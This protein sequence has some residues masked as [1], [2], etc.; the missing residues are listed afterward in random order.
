MLKASM[1][2]WK[3]PHVKASSKAAEAEGQSLPSV[4]S[5]V[6]DSPVK[7]TTSKGPSSPIAELQARIQTLEE[8]N[9]QLRLA[10]HNLCSSIEQKSQEWQRL[11]EAPNQDLNDF[12]GKAASHAKEQAKEIKKLRDVDRFWIAEKGCPGG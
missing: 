2:R 4:F 11:R 9:Q 7:A 8:E 6:K 10:N 12:R 1:E 3:S 5:P